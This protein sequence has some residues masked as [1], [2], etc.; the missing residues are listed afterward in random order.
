MS[1]QAKTRYRPCRNCGHMKNELACESC[2]PDEIGRLHA[3]LKELQGILKLC[4]PVTKEESGVYD[5]ITA[6]LVRWIC[7][8]RGY[9]NVMQAVAALWYAKDPNGAFTCGPCAATVRA[10]IGGEDV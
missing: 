8:F 6:S 1:N 4:A 5:R 9:G 2:W 3:E 10:A 7:E